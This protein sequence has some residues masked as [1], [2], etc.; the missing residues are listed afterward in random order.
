MF[1]DLLPPDGFQIDS[2]QSLGVDVSANDFDVVEDEALRIVLVLLELFYLGFI[3]LVFL[4][5]F[6]QN[7]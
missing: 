5:K 2:L 7:V 1:D 6:R 4:L 3:M